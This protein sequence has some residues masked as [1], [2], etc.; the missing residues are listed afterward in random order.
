MTVD[1]LN[2]IT[3]YSGSDIDYPIVIK[4]DALEDPNDFEENPRSISQVILANIDVNKYTE[5][6]PSLFKKI[7]EYSKKI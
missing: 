3:Y 5:L 7:S 2:L 6:L 1:D 4:L